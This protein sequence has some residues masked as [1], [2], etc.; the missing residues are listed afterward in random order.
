MGSNPPRGKIILKKY[1]LWFFL[2]KISIFYIVIHKKRHKWSLFNYLKVYN[3]C[4]FSFSSKMTFSI[5]ERD[6]VEMKN[7][8]HVLNGWEKTIM[9]MPSD[10]LEHFFRSLILWKFDLVHSRICPKFTFL[11][12]MSSDF[13]IF[14]KLCSTIEP[15]TCR[16]L[17]NPWSIFL[18]VDSNLKH[19]EHLTHALNF[20]NLPQEMVKKY[21]W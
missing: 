19:S 15:F 17:R 3:N 10:V 6:V 2:T 20:I 13:E 8:D 7:W 18:E 4:S 12:R 9:E 11:I 14:L 16:S 21:H 1:F 5:S